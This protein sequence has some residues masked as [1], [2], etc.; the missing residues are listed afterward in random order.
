MLQAIAA[1]W[2]NKSPEQLKKLGDEVGRERIVVVHGEE[3]RM[4]GIIHGTKLIGYLQP[5]LHFVKAGVGHV[6]FSKF[7][8]F[9]CLCWIFPV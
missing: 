1:G 6:F 9:T 7:C 3:D 8:F 2:H 5:G 4:I